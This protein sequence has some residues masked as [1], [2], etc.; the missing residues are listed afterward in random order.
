MAEV[1]ASIVLTLQDRTSAGF[2][3]VK[4]AGSEAEKQIASLAGTVNNLKDR[5]EALNKSYASVAAQVDLAKKAVQD[6]AKA[7]K[8][9]ATDANK[10]TLE[11]ARANLKGLTDDLKTWEAASKDTRAEI[12]ELQAQIRALETGGASGSA[13]GTGSSGGAGGAVSG[14]GAGLSAMGKQLA[15]SAS[16]YLSYYL[17]SSL[18]SQNAAMTS[19]VLSGIM[20]GASAGA[21]TGN[22]FGVSIGAAV[23][24]VAGL[25]S[26]FTAK[27]EEEDSVFKSYR[28]EL[29][30][31]VSDSV[32]E[33]LTTGSPIAATREQNQIAF[34]TLIGAERTA[35]LLPRI[36]E[37]ANI[38]PYMYDDLVSIARKLAVYESTSDQIYGRLNTIG[39]TGAALGLSASRMAD[40]A[41]VLGKIGDTDVWRKEFSESLLGYGVN[42]TSLIA[43]YYGISS[44]EASEMLSSMS[45]RDAMTAIMAAMQTRYAGSMEAQSYTY[46]GALS[47][48]EGLLQNRDAV[49]G[50]A[51]NA[52]RVSG[53]VTQNDWL[54][55]N[56]VQDAFGVIGEALAQKENFAD[57]VGRAV[58]GGIFGDGTQDTSVLPDAAAGKVAEYRSEYESL[59]REYQTADSQ[60]Q[61]EIGA[62]IYAIYS[63]AQMLAE[64]SVTT[65]DEMSAWNE[66]SITLV[67][68]GSA[69]VELL[70]AH[71]LLLRQQVAATRGLSAARSQRIGSTI[72]LSETYASTP[73]IVSRGRPSALPNSYTGYNRA[74]GQRVIPYDDYLISAHEGEMLLT[75]AEARN[76]AAG[77]RGGVA[78]TGNTFVV[79]QDS[80]I[81][82]IAQAL[83]QKIAQAA[84]VMV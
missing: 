40:L 14:W 36:Q 46:A 16:G 54:S 70:D 82:A 76:Y 25:L 3:A 17:S 77:M 68:Q 7:Y 44:A 23:G 30:S 5:N 29:I 79:R 83:A 28:D 42:P 34:T 66:T 45:G 60:R 69:I 12:R 37:L 32:D 22:I 24:G 80:D 38:T 72:D 84:R 6:A 73:K 59:M 63:E 56:A 41:G 26:G 55:Q 10:S 74:A 47:T 48:N 57:A 65:A 39:N 20:S 64:A 2:L 81:D 51:Y 61:M 19:S 71:T 15:G 52:A 9:A 18:G 1:D 43:G 49:M 21:L 67:E 8:D 58:I 53:L 50:E 13:G 33:S 27:S 78:V 4:R 11:E 35:S 62:D 75:A 31:S